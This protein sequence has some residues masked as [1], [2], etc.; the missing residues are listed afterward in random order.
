MGCRQGVEEPLTGCEGLQEQRMCS[1]GAGAAKAPRTWALF[2]SSPPGTWGSPQLSNA[3]LSQLRAALIWIQTL[4]LKITWFLGLICMSTVQMQSFPSVQPVHEVC[5]LCVL[6]LVIS[7]NIW[8][9]IIRTPVL[10][11]RILQPPE[12][13]GAECPDLTG[14]TESITEGSCLFCHA[15]LEFLSSWDGI[16]CTEH[17]FCISQRSHL[18][19]L[20]PASPGNWEY[21]SSTS[22]AVGSLA[23]KAS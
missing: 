6:I 4:H 2:I 17:R 8:L 19:E 22:P 23:R 5:G 20:L 1:G 10:C 14:L 21:W 3:L 7:V 15:H 9:F 12:R 11:S 16:L 13:E 18:E